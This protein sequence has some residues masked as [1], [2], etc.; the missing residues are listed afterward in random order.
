VPAGRFHDEF[1]GGNE[2]LFIG[3][4]D[5]FAGANRCIGRF[6]PGNPHN[7]RHYGVDLG[8]DRYPNQGFRPAQQFRHRAIRNPGTGKQRAQAIYVPGILNDYHLGS[9]FLNLGGK[10]IDVPTGGEAENAETIGVLSNDV[11]RIRTY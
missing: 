8:G 9:E 7:G 2:N 6:E 11:Q 5:P 4:T 10:K 1:A 3:E